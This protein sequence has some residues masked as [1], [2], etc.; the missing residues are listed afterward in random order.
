MVRHRSV[1]VSPRTAR[2]G[3]PS[4]DQLH[5]QLPGTT[6]ALD[7][8]APHSWHTV[9]DVVDQVAAFVGDISTLV[10][11]RALLHV[12]LS[13]V[14]LRAAT[15]H[16]ATALQPPS[17]P[18]FNSCEFLVDDGDFIPLDREFGDRE[19]RLEYD[20]ARVACGVP[21]AAFS[22]DVPQSQR[23]FFVTMAMLCEVDAPSAEDQTSDDLAI[24]AASEAD[25][26]LQLCP[27]IVSHG[28]SCQQCS[29]TRDLW[30]LRCNTAGARRVRGLLRAGHEGAETIPCSV[31]QL[32]RLRMLDLAAVNRAN[33]VD[34]FANAPL[35]ECVAVPTIEVDAVDG[36]TP[37]KRLRSLRIGNCQAAGLVKALTAIPSLRCLAVSIVHFQEWNDAMAQIASNDDGVSNVTTLSIDVL[38]LGQS[39]ADVPDALR[40][41]EVPPRVFGALRHLRIGSSRST[42]MRNTDHSPLVNVDQIAA[43]NLVTFVGSVR[44]AKPRH[45]ARMRNLVHVAAADG[46]DAGSD[47][48]ALGGIQSFVSGGQA[49]NG[50]LCGGDARKL[51]VLGGATNG[52]S[53]AAFNTP[54]PSLEHLNVVF[55][56]PFAF[57]P[58]WCTLFRDLRSLRSLTL[59]R[60]EYAL[61]ASSVPDTFWG[62][63]RDATC[64]E[65]IELHGFDDLPPFCDTV[66]PSR[67]FPRL[68]RVHTTGNCDRM[69]AAASTW[70][71]FGGLR[72]L[73]DLS[74]PLCGR[75]ADAA[76]EA[77]AVGAEG[78]LKALRSLKLTSPIP[79]PTESQLGAF[80]Q[81]CPR[82]EKLSIRM[83][84]VASGEFLS[85]LRFPSRLQ[86]LRVDLLLNDGPAVA[87]TFAA[88][89]AG[90]HNLRRLRLSGFPGIT[91]AADLASLLGPLSRGC[92]LLRAVE[93]PAPGLPF[94][95]GTCQLDPLNNLRIADHGANFSASWRIRESGTGTI[96]WNRDLE[97]ARTVLKP[98]LAVDGR[99]DSA[100]GAIAPRPFGRG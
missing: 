65:S 8:N 76:V 49:T 94:S 28:V 71:F 89:A 97:I 27:A 87:I 22:D 17:A 4:E 24:A 96:L 35:L 60:F 86:S 45:I 7:H 5:K 68:H 37:L 34:I 54:L 39:P 56:L 11:K 98:A 53:P 26:V 62:S 95:D 91:H 51:R 52:M 14:R 38:Q 32:P 41:V 100:I 85:S 44:D 6:S 99:S 64:L 19:S 67:G 3:P 31:G 10:A 92:P 12:F 70:R 47:L 90:L 29:P 33:F 48:V 72:S 13:A 30:A 80:L 88:H 40:T 57:A 1:S 83:C 69:L 75:Y 55:H 73:S 84:G 21:L 46:I 20:G 2:R 25:L 82:V 36:L 74:V 61:E 43:L 81:L 93:L 9:A 79:L 50:F 78:E 63:L 42:T 18:H 23:M 66:V 16:A 15:A 77:L 59:L 58:A